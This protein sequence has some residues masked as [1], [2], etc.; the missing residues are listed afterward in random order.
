MPYILK[1]YNEL[2]Q[3]T[4]LIPGKRKKIKQPGTKIRDFLKMNHGLSHKEKTIIFQNRVPI[5]N[6]YPE[7]FEESK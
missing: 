7:C 2:K 1:S 6:N 5:V 4:I 3:I